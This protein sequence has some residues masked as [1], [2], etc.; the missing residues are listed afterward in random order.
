M[1]RSKHNCKLPLL[2]ILTSKLQLTWSSGCFKGALCSRLRPIYQP[3]YCNKN[4]LE[5]QKNIF[6]TNHHYK[7]E[8][9]KTVNRTPPTSKTR[10]TVTRHLCRTAWELKISLY[11]T[12][13][14]VFL[15]LRTT[16]QISNTYN[17]FVSKWLTDTMEVK[18]FFLR[19]QR[20]N[21]MYCCQYRSL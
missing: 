1:Y 10:S 16:C 2:L 17:T 8:V 7:R 12:L 14:I 15:T 9:C 21:A 3:W 20:K 18:T 13:C 4:M 6:P 11:G 5:V 19:A